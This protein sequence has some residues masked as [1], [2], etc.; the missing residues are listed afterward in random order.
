MVTA[1]KTVSSGRD[2]ADLLDLI[3]RGK[4]DVLTFTSPSTVTNFIDIM[5]ADWTIPKDL[6]I[7]CIGPVTEA[8]AK[9]AGLRIDIVQGPYVIAGLVDAIINES[10]N[11]K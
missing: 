8:A 5:G 9:K 4:V 2:R 7:A 11:D 3:D 1:Y 10:R 6:K